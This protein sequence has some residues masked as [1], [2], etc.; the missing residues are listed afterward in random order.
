[1]QDYANLS[2]KVYIQTSHNNV[3]SNSELPISFMSIYKDDTLLKAK[4][5]SNRGQTM[6]LVDRYD[7]MT[8]F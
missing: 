7:M 1:M 5:Q 2:G 8:R 3:A 4:C 6:I